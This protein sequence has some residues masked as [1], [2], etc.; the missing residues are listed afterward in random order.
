MRIRVSLYWQYD[1][2]LI[3]LAMHPDFDFAPWVKRAIAAYARGD[4]NFYIPLPRKQPYRT[5]LDNYSKYI[6]LNPASDKDSIQ[7]LNAIRIG[8]RN[9][10]IK[11]ILRSYLEGPFMDAFLDKETY[12]TKRDRVKGAPNQKNNPASDDLTEKAVSSLSKPEKRK[13]KAIPGQTKKEKPQLKK[14]VL[15]QACAAQVPHTECVEEQRTPKAMDD[16]LSDSKTKI[17]APDVH[18]CDEREGDKEESSF[19]LFAAIDDI[20][21]Q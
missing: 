13:E 1:L 18:P 16:F 7:F 10:T 17:A 9:S 19:D 2:D 4:A 14:P 11:Q 12:E 20:L 8:F 6:T 5:F 15:E 3:A 21:N